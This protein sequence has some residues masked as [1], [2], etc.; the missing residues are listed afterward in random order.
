MRCFSAFVI[1]SLACAPL[2]VAAPTSDQFA[3]QQFPNRKS[4]ETGPAPASL[5]SFENRVHQIGFRLAVANET[6]CNRTA[7]LT[8]MALHD[9]GAYRESDR[10]AIQKAYRL[11]WGFGVFELVPG[12]PAILAGLQVGDEIAEANGRD[13]S[14]FA[15][16]LIGH[17]GSIERTRVMEDLLAEMMN[18]GSVMLVVRRDERRVKLNLTGVRGCAGSFVVSPA[19]DIDAWSDGVDVAISVPL[20]EALQSD[21]ELAFVLGHEMAHNI[22]HHS[23]ALRWSSRLFANL[24]IGAEKF[25]QS[26][27]E[28]DRLA[29]HMVTNAGYDWRAAA[30]A[31]AKITI[32]RPGGLPPT[33]PPLMARIATIEREGEAIS[34]STH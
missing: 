6:L 10:P 7:M 34:A 11:G 31:L 2:A 12:G 8:G 15:M 22:F 28:A 26:E 3:T 33:Y 19:A 16:N 1:A 21:D 24:G 9:V 17:R 5:S 20:A 23:A 14:G 27:L 25:R 32:A 30:G 18:S 4:A 13:L 29:V